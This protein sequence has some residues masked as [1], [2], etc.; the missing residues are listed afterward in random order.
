MLI[1]AILLVLFVL[2]PGHFIDF[3]TLK[4]ISMVDKSAIKK[5]FTAK[6]KYFFE[7][8]DLFKDQVYL[9]TMKHKPGSLIALIFSITMPIAG[10]DLAL[11]HVNFSSL[12]LPEYSDIPRHNF[13]HNLMI[14]LGFTDG[15]DFENAVQ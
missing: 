6:F 2:V 13:I 12:G 15:S 3:Y 4:R 1:Y 11:N 9:Y 14:Y 7:L 8:L 5:G 10:A